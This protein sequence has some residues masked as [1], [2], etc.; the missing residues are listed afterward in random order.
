[1]L[2]EA[3]VAL[4]ALTTVLIAAKG[5]KLPGPGKVYGDGI[6]KYLT[7]IIG[8]QNF[9]FAAT[10]GAM[11]F[12]TF[13]FDTLD[14]STR[15]GRYI[16]QELFAWKT[17]AAGVMAAALTLIPPAIFIGTAKAPAPGVRPAYMDFWTLF[18][19]SNQLLAALTL[20]AVTVWLRREK[21]RVWY[22]AIPMVF[23][24]AIT[25]WALAL[26]I[27]Q[28]F[29]NLGAGGFTLNATTMNGIVGLALIA[30]AIAL[31]FEAAKVLFGRGNIPE[32]AVS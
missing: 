27:R 20:L 30:L 1:M 29:T 21:R 28:A 14:V 9:L 15:L 31:M 6:G 22:T 17:R 7:V 19:T 8:K 23:V 4:I 18:G 16:I 32:Q 26:Q 25:L 12:S 2:L 13:V 5:V 11:A 24:M 3:F 10:F